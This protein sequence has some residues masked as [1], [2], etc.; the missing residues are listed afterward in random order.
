MHLPFG[1]LSE[2]MKVTLNPTCPY[3]KSLDYRVNYRSTILFFVQIL[4]HNSFIDTLKIFTSSNVAI[5]NG[6]KACVMSFILLMWCCLTADLF[7]FLKV[8]A[9][10]QTYVWVIFYPGIIIFI[11]YVKLVFEIMSGKLKIILFD[12]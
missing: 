9:C 1:Y 2:N 11:V 4:F 10:E 12:S 6:M 7:V 8:C 5:C 3:S